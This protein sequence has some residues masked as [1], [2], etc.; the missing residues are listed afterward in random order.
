MQMNVNKISLYGTEY[1]IQDAFARAQ[2]ASEYNSETNYIAGDFC[3]YS[4]ALYKCNSATS[5]SWASSNWIQTTVMNEIK[6]SGGGGEAEWEYIEEMERYINGTLTDSDV[7]KNNDLKY[8][9]NETF[10]HCTLLS[11][12]SFPDCSFIGNSAFQYMTNLRDVD[13]TNC[14]YIGEN[15]FYGCCNLRS[16]DL[17]NCQIIGKSAFADF[18]QCSLS[19][20]I[21]NCV[22]IE[23]NAFANSPISSPSFPNCEIIRAHAFE[24]CLFSEISIPK[25]ITIGSEAFYGCSELTSIDLPECT[26]IWGNAFDGC[27]HLLSVYL[28][29]STMCYL[30]DSSAFEHTPIQDSSYLGYFGTIYVPSTFASN[31]FVDGTWNWYSSRMS[32]VR[33]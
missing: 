10:R 9:P 4:D 6:N 21:P 14:I 30:R 33:V 22:I 7:A 12:V 24:G 29:H 26:F 19:L 3:L 16:I 1:D 28:T 11:T 15:A 27:E 23:E 17:R 5:G 32:I 2:I 20:S 18:Q 8:I 25:C 31:Y 13:A